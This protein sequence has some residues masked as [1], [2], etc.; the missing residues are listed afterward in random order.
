VTPDAFERWRRLR[1]LLEELVELPPGA[2]E[3][4]LAAVEPALAAEARALLAAGGDEASR[5]LEGAVAAGAAAVIAD[6]GLDPTR[7]AEGASPEESGAHP[8]LEVGAWRLERPLGRGG[9]AEVWE[10]R[11]ADGQFE[12]TVAVKLLKRGMDSA[13]I[14]RRFL[15]ERQ[16]LAHLDHPGIAR[17][18]DG[19][20]GPDGR[21][22]FVLERV[23]G[24]P[25]TDWCRRR[26]L[27]V[28]ARLRLLVACCQAVAAAHR[29]LVVHRDLKPSNILVTA[30][31]PGGEGQVKLLDFG[32]AK[33]LADDDGAEATRAEA[34]MLTPSYA[35]P[36]Q[37]LGE[38]VSTATDVYALGVLAYELLV[39]RLP[40]RRSGRGAAEL[41]SGLANESIV[42]PST[43]VLDA[44][45]EE[46]TAVPLPRERRRLARALAGDLD[47]VVMK[48]LRRE[49][50]RRYA[51]VAA[52]AED[53]ERYLAGRPVLA[54]PDSLGYRT[55]KF[56]GRHRLGVAA[57]ALACAALLLL[58]VFA[59]RQARRAETSARA[60]REEAAHA[61][62]Q[63]ARAER[64]RAFL[65]SI[66]AV[67][68][69][70]RA[71]GEQV[72]ARALLDEGVRRV[73]GELAGEPAL[74]GEMLD[75]LAGLYRKLG[76]LDVARPLAERALALRVATHGPRSAEAARSEWT[77][78]WVLS[79]QGELEA[80]H[81]RLDHAIALLDGVEGPDSLAAADAREPLV[82]VV[83]AAEGPAATLPVAQRRLATY[84]RV[85]GE[86][87]VRTALALS[88]VALVLG[89]L[90]R[91]PEAEAGYRRAIAVLDS[92]LP[93][94][95]PRAAYPHNNLAELLLR[96]GRAGEAEKEVRRAVAIR[97]RSLG[98]GHPES[99]ASRGILIQVLMTLDRLPEAERN[100]REALRLL[101]DRDRF[102]ATQMRAALGQVLL[103]AHRYGEAL[104]LFEQA[105]AERRGMIPDDHVLM[106]AVRI[107][108]AQALAG[109]G[110]TAE[111]R[112][113]LAA[114]VP[115]LEAKGAEGA[116]HLARVREEL[117]KLGGP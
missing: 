27:D 35:A 49:P 72:T 110:R 43:A 89:E 92:E 106:F 41:V 54:R 98:P 78:G 29:R 14:V 28:P 7:R 26:G 33:L 85:A 48:A 71:R 101:G 45:R 64:V 112:A 2:R 94:D 68:D 81:K 51:S 57:A 56:V 44:A 79:N 87:D 116:H 34:R 97:E 39:G 115:P 61:R 67:S 63:A 99:I 30:G 88:D 32:I 15:R 3:A 69:P 22:Y 55:R 113:A 66:F 114:L 8:G 23:E 59:L 96:T 13:E 73:D 105:I 70:V 74:H 117:A 82:E 25:I 108:R 24:E 62:Q 65:T 50:E 58:T 38:P 60:A 12:Q 40:H 16:I 111:A 52:F 5:R 17:L 53:V 37:I 77:L 80:A 18:F 84:R 11:R 93:A 21:P 31:G 100:A 104:P 75:L 1:P 42:R 102:A 91:L 83:F 9:M 6:L 109:L 95:D 46:E 19:G 10:A 86:R 103:R 47:T 4:R 90:A 76:A 107:N 20:L 36:E